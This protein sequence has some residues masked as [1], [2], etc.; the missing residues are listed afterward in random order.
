MDI[1]RPVTRNPYDELPHFPSFTLTSSML[2]DGE[3]MPVECTGDGTDTSPDLSWSGFPA[4]TRSFAVTC[5]DPDA[6][7][8]SGFWHWTIV[9]IPLSTTS[10]DINAGQ[11]DSKLPEGAYHIR[12]DRSTFDYI[13]SA[14]PHGD[15]EHRY[16]FAVH[17]LEVEHLDLPQDS[18]SPTAAA[19]TMLFHTCARAYITATYSR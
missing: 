14:P 2:K 16:I 10:L 15:H 18:T 5:F 7:T 9:N 19:F 11:D 4:T 13:G 17:A 3:R 6:P 12:N 1:T 8:P